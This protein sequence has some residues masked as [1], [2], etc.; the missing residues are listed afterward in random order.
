M[1]FAW[2]MAQKPVRR[3]DLGGIMSGK[4]DLD[5]INKICF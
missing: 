1:Y 2:T 4:D 5:L 3:G